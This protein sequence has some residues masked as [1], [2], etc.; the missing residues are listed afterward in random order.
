M[1]QPKLHEV[2]VSI[3]RTL[4][5]HVTARFSTLMKPTGLLSDAFKFYIRRLVDVGYVVKNEAGMYEL[6]TKGKEFAN[7]LDET[8]LLVQKQPKISVIVCATKPADPTR[9]LFQRRLRQPYYGFYGTISGP[10]RWG[11]SFEQAAARELAKQTG[12]QASFAVKGFYRQQDYDK[13]ASVLLEDKL[14]VVVEALQ[15][16]G[17]LANTWTG[18]HNQWMTAKEYTQESKHFPFIDNIFAGKQANLLY[19]DSVIQYEAGDY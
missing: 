15:V 13:A 8:K 18:G 17:E 5:R 16:T 7:N 9:F 3:L 6:T 19:A 2:E 14:F 12:L 10:V 4:R 1:K 11:E